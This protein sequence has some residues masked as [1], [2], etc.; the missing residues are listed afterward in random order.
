[1][2]VY[3]YK[4]KE[5]GVFNELA[6]FEES[7]NPQPCPICGELSARIIRLA[8]ELFKLSPAERNAHETNERSSHEPIISSQEQREHDDHHRKHCGCDHKKNK[9]TMLLTARGEKM[10]PSSR[11]WMISH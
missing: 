2:P 3:D 6:T 10:F 1:M 9:R 8:P 11:P 4:C 5:H 7:G